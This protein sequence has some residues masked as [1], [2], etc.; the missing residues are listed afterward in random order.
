[1]SQ[2]PE[3]N[4]KRVVLGMVSTNCY[5]ISNEET[6]EAIL[7]DPASNPKELMKELEQEGLKAV[8]LMV[9]HGHFD[10][11]LAINELKE[12]L[13]VPLYAHEAEA[14]LLQ[15]ADLNCSTMFGV[16]GGYTTTA[17]YL[18]KDHEEVEIAG[19]RIQVLHTPGHT[20]GGCCYYFVDYGFVVTGDTLFCQS[21]G[22]TDLPT[23]DYSTLLNSIKTQL[24]TLPKE[25]KVFPG[26][27]R[28]TSIGFEME[29][30]REMR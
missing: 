4:I 6:K 18:L 2:Y 22:R 25:T 28:D 1:M 20:A 21:I 26:H 23:G 16:P 3:I 30:N 9:T 12:A 24:F 27:D 11:I 19:L 7:I 13:H 29:H 17:E 5:I 8:A 14:T 15:S 10:H